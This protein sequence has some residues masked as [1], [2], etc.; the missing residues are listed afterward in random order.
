MKKRILCFGDSNTWGYIPGIGTRYREDIRWTGILANELGNDFLVIEEGLNGRTTVFSDLMEPERCGIEHVRPIVLSQ[1]PLDYVVVM[2]GS[3]DTKTHFHVNAKEIGYGMEELLL[4][5][6]FVLDLQNS[7]AKIILV[8]PIHIF[9]D[10][11]SMFD[12]NSIMKSKELAQIY[13]KLAKDRNWLY[14][15]AAAV[16]DHAGVDGIHMTEEGHL[17]LGK[18]FAKLIN[19]KERC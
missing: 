12:E 7:K 18:A 19:E 9:S 8:S 3:N 10:E 13:E 2:L 11:D 14:M 6:K 1:L 17:K 4:K 16:V 5:M 15:N